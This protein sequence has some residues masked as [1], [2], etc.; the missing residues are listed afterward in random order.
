LELTPIDLTSSLSKRI[1]LPPKQ[2]APHGRN[3]G[4]PWQLTPSYAYGKIETL[5]SLAFLSRVYL[6]LAN[7]QAYNTRQRAQL[8]VVEIL[9]LRPSG[10]LSDLP[11]GISPAL[12]EAARTMQLIAV[13]DWTTDAYAMTGRE[14]LAECNMSAPGPVKEEGYA[15]SHEAMVGFNVNL[16]IL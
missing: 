13:T 9:R 15:S 7:Q 10:D 12:H 2:L 6:H 1:N 3:L 8:G 14:D 11:L 5:P 4:A 16:I